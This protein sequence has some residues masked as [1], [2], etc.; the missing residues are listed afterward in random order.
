VGATNDITKKLQ[1]VLTKKLA[2]LYGFVF[3]NDPIHSGRKPTAEI[4]IQT[5]LAL[6]TVATIKT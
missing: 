6:V 5:H 3:I 4:F 2:E 1:A